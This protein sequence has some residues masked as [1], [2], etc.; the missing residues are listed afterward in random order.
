MCQGGQRMVDSSNEPSATAVANAEVT[1][2][3][4]NGKVDVAILP[5]NHDADLA[6]AAGAL[7]LNGDTDKDLDAEP[8][9]TNECYNCGGKGHWARECTSP[10]DALKKHKD[11]GP[12]CHECQGK[13]HLFRVCPTTLSSLA[14][15]LNRIAFG[16]GVPRVRGTSL[17]AMEQA[18]EALEVKYHMAQAQAR[19][20]S[21]MAASGMVQNVNGT[22][23]YPQGPYPYPAPQ[24][25]A[26]QPQAPPAYG[27]NLSNPGSMSLSQPPTPSYYNTTP[28]Q[29]NGNRNASPIG[30]QGGPVPSNDVRICRVCGQM[31]H[32]ARACPAKRPQAGSMGPG[33]G[34]MVG[35]GMGAPM[36]LGLGNDYMMPQGYMVDTMPMH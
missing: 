10:M 26:P 16:P 33:P 18:V 4:A 23:F 14:M 7:S 29:A 32:I 22:A 21:Y 36:G 25:S 2:S 6:S 30:S 19:M 34:T 5:V 13:G 3:V 35:P 27:Q 31:G 11:G 12:V 28:Q 8:I 1:M 9:A 20:M 17:R 24:M 15:R